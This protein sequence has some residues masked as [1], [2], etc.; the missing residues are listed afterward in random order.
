MILALTYSVHDLSTD[1]HW[2]GVD[3]DD[4]DHTR[5]GAAV[6]PIVDRPALYEESDA[7]QM[8]DRASKLPA[9]RS[10]TDDG[11]LD[12]I[13]PVVP[14]PHTARKRGGAKRRPVVQCRA[15]VS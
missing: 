12:R 6:D 15:D 11:R 9:E 13:R 5:R 14:P 7:F 3:Q 4:S 8:H 1:L 2:L 10:R